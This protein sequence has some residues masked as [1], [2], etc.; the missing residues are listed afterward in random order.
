KCDLRSHFHSLYHRTPLQLM[1][2]N[3]PPEHHKCVVDRETL[4]EVYS[5]CKG[6]HVTQDGEFH[7]IRNPSRAGYECTDEQMQLL[8]E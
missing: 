4:E 2:C 8:N 1:I 6:L 7:H 5:Y 3:R